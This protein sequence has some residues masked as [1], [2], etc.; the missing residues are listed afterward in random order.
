MGHLSNL[1]NSLIS[2]P[3]TSS[4]LRQ[5]LQRHLRFLIIRLIRLHL[6]VPAG[7]QVVL[8]RPHLGFA[9]PELARELVDLGLQG[10]RRASSSARRA[11]AAA[12]PP[13]QFLGGN[14]SESARGQ[15]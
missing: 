11:W 7:G 12:S 3:I 1:P 2:S 9:H 5:P 8:V 14:L 4:N 10:A 15:A 13:P 6:A